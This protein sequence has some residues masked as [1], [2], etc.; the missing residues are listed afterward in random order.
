LIDREPKLI[1]VG[2]FVDLRD[3]YDPLIARAPSLGNI[4]SY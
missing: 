4:P 1:A 3:F 2:Q